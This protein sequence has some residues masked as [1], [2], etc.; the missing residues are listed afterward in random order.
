M[1]V[2]TNVACPHSF[3]VAIVEEPVAFNQDLKAFVPNADV[4]SEFVLG[5]GSN[6][7]R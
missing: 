6:S 4:D 2:R 1:V 5:G 7:I 3:P